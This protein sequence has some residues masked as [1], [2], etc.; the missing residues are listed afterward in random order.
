M[1]CNYEIGI[2]IDDNCY[3]ILCAAGDLDVSDECS[4]W[5]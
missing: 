2:E 4:N 1:K 3:K 5:V